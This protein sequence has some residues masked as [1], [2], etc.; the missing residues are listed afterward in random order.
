MRYA[1][2]NVLTKIFAATVAGPAAERHYLDKN[3]WSCSVWL[4]A[5]D[6]YF[7]FFQ[8]FEPLWNIIVALSLD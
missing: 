2:C 3:S 8:V 6:L 5:T 1:S 7:I 4:A